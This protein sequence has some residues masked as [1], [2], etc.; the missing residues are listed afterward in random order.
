MKF[1]KFSDRF[2]PV[3]FFE[4]DE[5]VTVTLKICDETDRKVIEAAGKIAAADKL[6]EMSR[7]LEIY[8]EALELLIGEENAEK[9]LSKAEERDCF[10]VSEVIQYLLTA[11]A[12]QKRKN[13]QASGR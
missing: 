8:L 4:E 13:L 6:Q 11:Y 10:A 3:R 12:E 1:F 2:V 9:I 5:Q 7:R